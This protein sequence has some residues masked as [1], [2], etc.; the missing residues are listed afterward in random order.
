MLDD[1]TLSENILKA[2][3]AWA[4]GQAEVRGVALVGSRA[5][6]LAGVARTFLVMHVAAVV[7][8]WRF[9]RG[10]QKVTW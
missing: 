10:S 4:K 5:G 1:C 6:R 3:T 2:V 8:L 9:A 7:G